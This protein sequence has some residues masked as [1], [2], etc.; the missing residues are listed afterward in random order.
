MIKIKN[1]CNINGK[2]YEIGE[3]FKPKKTDMPLIIRMNEKGFIEPMT[4][5]ELLELSNSFNLVESKKKEVQ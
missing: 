3:E 4:K 5:D 1:A 2:R